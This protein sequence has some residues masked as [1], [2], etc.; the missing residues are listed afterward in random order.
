VPTR[1]EDGKVDGYVLRTVSGDLVVLAVVRNTPDGGRVY[2]AVA[3]SID[4]K[5]GED[6]ALVPGALGPPLTQA[7]LARIAGDPA[8]T[9]WQPG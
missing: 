3:N 1:S 8:W 9:S 4:D 6:S 5:W 7:Q 2:V